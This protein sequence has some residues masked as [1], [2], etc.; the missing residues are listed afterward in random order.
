LFSSG[1]TLLKFNIFGSIIVIGY[2]NTSTD[3]TTVQVKD[4]DMNILLEISEEIDNLTFA[5]ELFVMCSDES[6]LV[7]LFISSQIGYALPFVENSNPIFN[8]LLGKHFLGCYSGNVAFW[9][10]ELPYFVVS[11][12]STDDLTK[13]LF[14]FGIDYYVQQKYSSIM[15][16]DVY[17][18]SMEYYPS[19]SVLRI[20]D[21]F[22]SLSTTLQYYGNFD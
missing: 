14:T 6:A 21:S 15:V 10:K 4:F 5:N 13:D 16:D 11:V 20:V 19:R 3:N 8:F 9:N 1:Q 7:M 18:I 2:K 17:S 12:I 22:F